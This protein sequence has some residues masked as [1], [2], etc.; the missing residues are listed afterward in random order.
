MF[1]M[2]KTGEVQITM[3][4]RLPHFLSMSFRSSYGNILHFITFDGNYYS[5]LNFVIIFSSGGCL[6]ALA[7]R[8]LNSCVTLVYSIVSVTS[9]NSAFS[10]MVDHRTAEFVVSTPNQSTTQPEPRVVGFY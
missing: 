7:H 4:A 2:V 5:H 10:L 8:P 3:S 1:Q 6:A 9:K